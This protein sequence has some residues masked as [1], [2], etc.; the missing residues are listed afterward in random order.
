MNQPQPG[1]A[2]NAPDHLPANIPLDAHQPDP[3]P[4]NVS[5]VPAADSRPQHLTPPRL[6]AISLLLAPLFLLTVLFPLLDTSL[7]TPAPA[8][9]KYGD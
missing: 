8:R 6:A 7:H 4:G 1:G 5:T 9:E 3:L 2:R